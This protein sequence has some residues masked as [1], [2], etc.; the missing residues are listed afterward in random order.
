MSHNL[1]EGVALSSSRKWGSIARFLDSHFH[2][3][4]KPTHGYFVI[5][6]ENAGS[7]KKATSLLHFFHE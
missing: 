5:S 2:G 6:F 7:F 4:D 3:N 1:G